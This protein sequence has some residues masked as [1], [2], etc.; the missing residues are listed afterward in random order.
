MDTTSNNVVEEDN[1]CCGK[2]CAK[3]GRL[4]LK[5][6]YINKTGYFCES[7]GNE[8]LQ[9]ALAVETEGQKK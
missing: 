3:L 9:Q 2:G 7:C 1:K 6:N 8:L 4:H 5:I